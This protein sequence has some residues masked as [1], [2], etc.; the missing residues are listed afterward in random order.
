MKSG[1]KIAAFQGLALYLLT[2]AACLV[3][4]TSLSQLTQSYN[5]SIAAVAALGSAFA[6]GRMVTVFITGYLT[7]KLGVKLIL[8]VGTFLLLVFL[9][10]LPINTNYN[11]G[12]ILAVIGGVGMGSQDACCP[13]ILS[14]AFPKHYASALS[15]GQALFGAGCFLPPMLMSI[16]ISL[17][18]PFYYPYFFIAAIAVVMLVLL[19]FAKIPSVEQSAQLL[20]NS[21]HAIKI[22]KKL[23][24]IGFV[25]L[26]IV[27][28][29]YCG[30]LNTINL[31]TAT[32]AETIGISAAVAVSLL[33][34]FNIG[35]MAGSMSFVKILMRVKPI[36][37]MIFNLCVVCVSLT[38]TIFIKNTVLLF[39]SLFITGLF[40]GVIFSILIMLSTGL[41][42]QN[43]ALAGAIV[44]VVAASSDSI[45][46]LITGNIASGAGVSFAFMYALLMA[47]ISLVFSVIFKVVTTNKKLKGEDYEQSK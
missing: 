29:A 25:L 45:N 31:Y 28:F 10:G 6:F 22:S 2:G 42:P 27:C 1:T 12:L 9:V 5:T 23:K 47:A 34:V 39:I 26:G 4:G 36:N 3:V 44:A 40:V 46:P 20:E 33:M 41:N 11:L 14:V 30:V 19:P 32:Y 7:K 24:I 15:A 38:A 43:A 17:N 21:D 37:A 13:V 16:S 18:M 8:G 35:S